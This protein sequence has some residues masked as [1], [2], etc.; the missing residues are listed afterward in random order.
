VRDLLLVLLCVISCMY[1]QLTP[2][3]ATTSTSHNLSSA[4]KGGVGF[5][6]P[7]QGLFRKA[8]YYR[9]FAM[10]SAERRAVFTNLL[11]QK[12]LVKAAC[13]GWCFD[14][15]LHVPTK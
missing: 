10:V 9:F 5:M 13:R 11:L 7:V 15:C 2:A 1:R 3:A 4:A 6:F 12:I 14:E 8:T